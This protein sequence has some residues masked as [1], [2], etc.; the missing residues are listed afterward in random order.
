[1]AEIADVIEVAGVPHIEGFLM[2][3]AGHAMLVEIGRDGH[4]GEVQPAQ[5]QGMHVRGNGVGKRRQINPAGERRGL[6]MRVEDQ[7]LRF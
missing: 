3:G 1:V 5:H 2:H 7:R 6:V 4:A